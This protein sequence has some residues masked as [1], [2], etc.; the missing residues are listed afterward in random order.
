VSFLAAQPDSLVAAAYD[1]EALGAAIRNATAASAGPTTKLMKMA[2]DE[3]SAAVAAVFSEHAELYQ[4]LS[5]Q[6]AAFHEEFVRSLSAAASAYATAEAANATLTQEAASA[7]ATSAANTVVL[8]MG[9]SGMPIPLTSYLNSVN[10]I[11]VQFLHPGAAIEALAIPAELYGDTGIRTIT[12]DESV[13]QGVTILDKAIRQ[14]IAAGN[15]VVVFG[16]SQSAT[17]ASMELAKLAALPA[18]LRPGVDQL[19]FVLVGDPNNPNGGVSERFSGL[20]LGTLGLSFSGSTPDDVYPTTIYTREYDG[21]ADFPRYPINLISNINALVGIYYQHG[22]YADLTATGVY[23]APPT[24]AELASAIQLPTQGPTLTTYYMIPADHLPLLQ[25]LRAI[26]IVGTPLANLIEPDLRV[27]VDLGYGD[28]AYGYSTGPANVPTPFGL[29][30]Q[31]VPTTILAALATGTQQGVS[32][33]CSDLASLPSPSV[34]HVSSG[35]TF[36]PVAAL[37][38]FATSSADAIKHVDAASLLSVSSLRSTAHG[39]IDYVQTANT[40]ISTAVS[41][42]VANHAAL[43]LPTADIALAIG[44]TLPSYDLN[45]FLDGIQTALEGNPYGLVD[46]IG[47][48]IAANTGLIPLA[49]FLELLSIYYYG[50]LADSAAISQLIAAL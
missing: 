28:P 49:L 16:Y 47:Y 6:A 1:I 23:S 37:S 45:L 43:L 10:D 27:I 7:A 22:S 24:A 40:A 46:A 44:V 32:Q 36:D 25:P 17:V 14:Q 5:S 20:T 13:A 21:Y 15:N 34:P 2:A 8:V 12:L 29:F 35:T 33:F 38:S 4:A 11:Y 50:I 30:P 48:P 39:A 3:V 41:T 18:D 26:P 9:P 19:S 42:I 31:V